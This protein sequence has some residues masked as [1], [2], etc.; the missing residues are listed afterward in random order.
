MVAHTM[1]PHHHHELMWAEISE[2]QSSTKDHSHHHD[3][4]LDHHHKNEDRDHQP[5]DASKAHS[6]P[7]PFHHHLNAAND[8][9]YARLNLGEKSSVSV[10]TISILYALSSFSVST[11]AKGKYLVRLKD[12]PFLIKSIFEP[13]ATGLRAPPSI[14]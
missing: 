6:H 13:G 10:K 3:S 8:F 4:D 12:K 11:E 14:A 5:K 1:I 7:F 9:D 2:V